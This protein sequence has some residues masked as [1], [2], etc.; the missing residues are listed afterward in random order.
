MRE[1]V[2]ALYKHFIN[3]TFGEVEEVKYMP[4]GNQAK[5]QIQKGNCLKLPR[6]FTGFDKEKCPACL[7]EHRKAF[8]VLRKVLRLTR[9]PNACHYTPHIK[10]LDTPVLCTRFAMFSRRLCPG[11]RVVFAKSKH[12]RHYLTFLNIRRPNTNP[13][14][15]G[16]QEPRVVHTGELATFPFPRN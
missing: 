11:S 1:Q 9:P 16:L 13:K 2:K 10:I 4:P 15:T 6:G 3:L 5:R 14:D 8:T 12:E 7:K